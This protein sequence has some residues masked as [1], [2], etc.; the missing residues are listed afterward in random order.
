MLVGIDVVNVMAAYQ[1]VVQACATLWRNETSV[2]TIISVLI[3]LMHGAN[4]EISD[5]YPFFF[6]TFYYPEKLMQCRVVYHTAIRVTISAADFQ[7]QTLKHRGN[8]VKKN[9]KY[10]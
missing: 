4:M 9:H 10:T 7:S 2:G 8:S 3:L 1:P 6:L 5:G